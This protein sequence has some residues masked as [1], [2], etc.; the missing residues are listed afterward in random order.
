LY[1]AG[2]RLGIY[3][4]PAHYYVP[5][6]NVHQLAKTR[7]RWARRSSLPGISGTPDEQGTRMKDICLPFQSEYAN[8]AVYRDAVAHRFGP[9]YGA[10]EAQALHA[11]V[12][13]FKPATIIEVGSGVSTACMTA[14][15]ARNVKDGA[16]KARIISIEPYPSAALMALPDIE[17]RKTPVQEISPDMFQKLAA[18]DLLFI[19]SSHT[20]RP[21]SDVNFLILEVLPR[22]APGVV[23]HF[24]DIYLPFDYQRDVLH[25]YFQWQ[26]TSL[27][28]AYLTE[29]PRMRIL[30]C[31]SQLHYDRPEVLREVFPEYRPA[32]G[33]DGLTAD[34]RGEQGAD[35]PTHF[36][37]SI[38]LQRL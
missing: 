27:L 18:G 7:S 13:H 32:S 20:V 12:R 25:T 23:V 38:Y 36:P 4:L 24:H 19:D 28:R 1:S 5:I 3:I 16:P 17:L 10:I 29:N 14:A 8:G 22:L 6:G 2:C 21:G 33:R 31:M 34:P 11:V 37:S 9:G 30:F 26:E 15:V 35:A